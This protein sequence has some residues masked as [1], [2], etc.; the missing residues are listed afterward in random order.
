VIGFRKKTGTGC[1]QALG[2][3]R[4]FNEKKNSK[5][6]EVYRVTDVLGFIEYIEKLMHTL[7]GKIDILPTVDEEGN[8][9][10]PFALS[11]YK[12]KDAAVSNLIEEIER[13]PG[14][15]SVVK[16]EITHLQENIM[17]TRKYKGDL[18]LKSNK[19]KYILAERGFQHHYDKNTKNLKNL[20]DIKERAL[21]K[22]SQAQ[23]KPYP[24]PYDV[25]E[26]SAQKLPRNNSKIS[27]IELSSTNN[28]VNNDRNSYFESEL[29]SLIEL[30]PFDKTSS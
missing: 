28:N 16:N 7:Q 5:N 10:C 12:A 2:I 29:N 4:M 24:L 1:I 8:S 3:N 6:N 19:E 27:D 9:E 22:I 26:K 30:G 17:Q 18:N 20:Q 23:K 21:K 15:I 13:V 25:G 11:L 14:Y